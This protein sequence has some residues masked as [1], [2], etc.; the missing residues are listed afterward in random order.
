[1]LFR[2]NLSSLFQV[3]AAI[4]LALACV[5]AGCSTNAGFGTPVSGPNPVG[6]NPYGPTPFPSGSE[7]PFEG[8]MPLPMASEVSSP[9]GSPSPTPTPPPNTLTIVGASLRLAYDG[10]ARD[11]VKAQRLL[12]LTFALENTTRNSA[13]I[14]SVAAFTDKTALGDSSVSVTAPASQTSEVASVVVKTSADPTQYKEIMVHFLDDQKKMIGT[15]R[16]DVP[17]I[18]TPFT[19]L[20]EKHPK[21]W[22]SID[23]AQISPISTSGGPHFECTFAIT[24][25]SAVAGAITEFDIKPP[26]GDLIKVA[27][28]ANVPARSV[29]GFVSIVAPYNG[30]KLPAGSYI[31]TAQ[32]GRVIVARASAVL[33]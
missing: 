7:V 17:P 10:A 32:Q 4:G 9:A 31:I 16:L 19:A 26:K 24:N 22:L 11:P 15:Q 8:G 12:E 27:I 25:A 2:K 29:T 28:P 23:S 3:L 33:L 20:D 6:P 18:D 13:K 21:G 14:A 30:K 1:M 5:L